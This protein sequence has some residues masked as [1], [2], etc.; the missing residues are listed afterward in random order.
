VFAVPS[1]STKII[2]AGKGHLSNKMLMPKKEMSS[3]IVT[4]YNDIMKGAATPSG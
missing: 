2:E 4:G 1:F 3:F